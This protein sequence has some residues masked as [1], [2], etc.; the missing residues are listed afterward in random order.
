VKRRSIIGI[1]VTIL[2]L[3]VIIGI[4]SLPDDVLIESSAIDNSQTIP[5]ETQVPTKENLQEFISEIGDKNTEVS[6]T[7]IDALKKEITDLKNEVVQI[8]INSDVPKDPSTI[9]EKEDVSTDKNS[10]NET[11]GK[12][13]TVSIKDGVGMKQR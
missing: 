7:E 5:E 1:S 11:E 8:K 9:T 12:V 13:I 3:S 4:A 10:Q 2:V 6:K